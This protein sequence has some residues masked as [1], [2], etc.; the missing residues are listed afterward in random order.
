M[1]PLI[2]ISSLSFSYGVVPVLENITFAINPGDFIAIIG[3]NGSGKTTLLRILLGFLSPTSG[4]VQHAIPQEQIGYVPQRYTIDKNFPGTV[5][6][7]LGT[8][9][10]SLFKRTG[11]EQF[12]NKK[13]VALSGGQQQ[14]VLIALALRQKPKLLFLDEPTAGVD[15]QAQ[16]E[17]YQLLKLLNHQGIAIVLVTHE[18]GVIPSLV[19]KVICINHQLCCVGKPSDIHHLLEKMYGPEFVVH[20]HKHKHSHEHQHGDS[21]V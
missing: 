9:D 6:E 21:R 15:I 3:P 18:V 14:R 13:F 19:K 7:I 16:R 4:K 10:S 2:S 20:R 1:K 12:V 17:F 5:R 8:E 11:I